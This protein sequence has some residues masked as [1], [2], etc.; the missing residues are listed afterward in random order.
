MLGPSEEQEGQKWQFLKICMKCNA[1][2]WFITYPILILLHQCIHNYFHNHIH[3]VSDGDPLNDGHTLIEAL[4]YYYNCY[5]SEVWIGKCPIFV[6]DTILSP[7]YTFICASYTMEMY[8]VI[9]YMW[10]NTTL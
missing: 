3:W 4:F 7:I 2:H 1:S 10:D 8:D 9:C 5:Y 6:E